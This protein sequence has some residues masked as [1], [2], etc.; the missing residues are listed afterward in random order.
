MSEYI[1]SN[2]GLF[3][4]T[5]Y[6]TTKSKNSLKIYNDSVDLCSL[7][8]NCFLHLLFLF[9]RSFVKINV[10]LSHRNNTKQYLHFFLGGRHPGYLEPHYFAALAQKQHCRKSYFHSFLLLW[11]ASINY[12]GYE[13]VTPLSSRYIKLKGI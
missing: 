8:V 13:C 10:G 6:C 9:M 2:T 4:L 11:S 12:F 5:T 3:K 1:P 7:P